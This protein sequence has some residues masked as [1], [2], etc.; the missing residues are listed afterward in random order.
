MCQGKSH[1]HYTH[2]LTY[3]HLNC[4][5]CWVHCEDNNAP[6][7][8]IQGK[9]YRANTG[10]AETAGSLDDKIKKVFQLSQDIL[11]LLASV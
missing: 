8:S 6:R 2:M 11:S 3:G 10:S 9:A 5:D 7:A 4:K 1:F